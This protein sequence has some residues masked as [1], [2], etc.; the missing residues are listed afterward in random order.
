MTAATVE[1]PPRALVPALRRVPVPVRDPEPATR[2]LDRHLEAP[3]PSAQGTLVLVL[4]TAPV[5]PPAPAR[6]APTAPPTVVVPPEVR[7]W[8]AMFVQAATEVASGLRP[9]YQLRRWTSSDLHEALQRRYDF[10]TQARAAGIY[11]AG[12]PIVRSLHMQLVQPGDYEVTGVVGDLER[13]RAV[14]LR[15]QRFSGRWRVTGLEIG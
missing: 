7:E 4:P 6:D 12:R 11:K 2:V 1:A 8:T 5:A 15:M 9:A 3:M 13:V 10:A 14:A